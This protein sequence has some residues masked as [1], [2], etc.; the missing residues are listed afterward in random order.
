MI[1]CKFCR[2]QSKHNYAGY[3]QTCYQ[4]FVVKGYDSWCPSNYG[5]VNFVQKEGHPQY[6]MPVCHICGRAYTK[7]IQHVRNNH[8]LTRE[9][10]CERYGLDKSVRMTTDIYHNKMS[11]YAYQYGM[12][13]SLPISGKEHRFKKGFSNNYKRSA[14]TMNRLKEYNGRKK[15]VVR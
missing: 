11:E 6:G 8:N 13:K 12:D 14:Q 15:N 1:F 10:Y 9:E 4:Y 3:C 5:E 2:K 7:L